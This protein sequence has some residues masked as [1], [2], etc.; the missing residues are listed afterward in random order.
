MSGAEWVILVH[1]P[2]DDL[3]VWRVLTRPLLQS[4]YS[5]MAIDLPGHGLSC[6]EWDPNIMDEVLV[7]L[8]AYAESNDAR[9]R[10]LIV[11]GIIA[12]SGLRA[13][14][15]VQTNGLV[16]L[17]PVTDADHQESATAGI[18]PKLI[19]VGSQTLHE[20][21]S[22]ERLFQMC[23]GHTLLSSFPVPEQGTDLLLSEWGEQVREQIILFLR[24]CG[25]TA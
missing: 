25:Q 10:Y 16:M 18:V 2:G 12:E 4:G 11:G 21:V 7:E 1:A 22:A 13:A 9:R 14:D 15:N 19:V 3:D 8:F 17:S 23:S 20:R 5:V 24:D 6:H